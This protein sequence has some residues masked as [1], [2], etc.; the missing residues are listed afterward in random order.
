[1]KEGSNQYYVYVHIRP[2]TKSIFYVGKGKGKR[3]WHYHNRNKHWQRIVNKNGG[4]FEVNLLAEGLTDEQAI[5]KER[6]YIALYGRQNLCNLT[7]GGES[8]E[9][10][11]PSIETR[12]RISASNKGRIMSPETRKKLSRAITGKVIGPC[13]P[14]V[15]EKI[16]RAN[17]GS[18]NGMFGRRI[19]E[20][21]KR[22]QR[23]KLS[24]EQNYLAKP[25]IN[26]QT[27][28]F[29][30][31]LQEAAE[32]IGMKRGTLWTMIAGVRKNKTS[33]QYA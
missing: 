17:S 31:T 27:G 8:N 29:Y 21:A 28:I 5:G 18:N 15:R 24:G 22:L 1:M 4:E 30:P 33:F 2:D 10:W 6:F 23:E 7:D 12:N 20:S 14:S 9:G 32:T 3:A 26:L 19:T 16:S 11:V 13:P 25:I